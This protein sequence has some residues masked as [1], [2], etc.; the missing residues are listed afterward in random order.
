MALSGKSSAT[1]VR[2]LPRPVKS[3][4]GACAYGLGCA[5]S[6]GASHRGQWKHS[7]SV[8]CSPD[9]PLFWT[10]PVHRGEPIE[11]VLESQGAPTSPQQLQLELEQAANR[12]GVGTA[13]PVRLA[14]RM[15]ATLTTDRDAAIEPK[16]E[17]TKQLARRMEQLGGGRSRRK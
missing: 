12:A 2:R 10:V 14:S 17:R 16:I 4:H 8:Q 11:A 3:R 5:V 13:G 1:Q 7:A 6:P 15:V 9:P